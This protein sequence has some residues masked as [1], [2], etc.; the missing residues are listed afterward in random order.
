[1]CY[2]AQT[3]SIL[4]DDVVT[5]K[6]KYVKLEESITLK[7][8]LKKTHESLQVT[9]EKIVANKHNT[10]GTYHNGKVTIQNNYKNVLNITLLSLNQTAITIWKASINDEGC[11]RC[12][13]NVKKFGAM[14]GEPCLYI[15]DDVLREKTVTVRHGKSAILNCVL[16]QKDKEVKQVTWQKKTPNGYINLATYFK[17]GLNIS[18]EYEN[19]LNI[20]YLDLNQTQIT[21]WKTRVKDEGC[22]RCIFNIRVTG[23]RNGEIC[24]NVFEPANASL[25]VNETKDSL[26]ATCVAT[27]WPK[28]VISWS[29][30]G[31]GNSN[32]S[33]FETIN[34][35]VTVTSWIIR[36]TPESHMAE[37]LACVVLHM[38]KETILRKEKKSTTSLYRNIIIVVSALAL[39]CSIAATVVCCRAKKRRKYF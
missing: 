7:C 28:P 14:E 5:E 15:S 26:N 2:F 33:K 39:V 34:G 4:H 29:G 21:V 6:K 25:H 12:I 31:M 16:R 32:D 3:M 30:V 10:I 36:N 13:F 18:K 24:L 38:G 17:T 27:G 22:Y 20:T 1:M 23:S 19:I 37:Q 35:L 9:W 11:Y 8:I